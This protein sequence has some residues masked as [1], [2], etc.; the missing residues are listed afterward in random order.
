MMPDHGE[1]KDATPATA[2][3]NHSVLAELPF[4][5]RQD[6]ADAARGFIASLPEMT[7]KRSDG[8][9]VYS[10]TDYAFLSRSDA[11]DTVNPSLWR[12]AR[13]NMHHGLFQVS[14]RI[15]Q[16]RGFD[17]SNMTIIEGER[18][19]IVIDPLISTETASAALE[20]YC[21]HRGRKPVTAVIYSHSHVVHFGGVR[22]VIDGADVA[23]GNVI[24]IAPD[25]FMEEVTK[26]NVLAGTPMVRR[27]MFQFGATLPKGERAQV[28]AGLGK[29]TS[30]GTVTLIPPTQTIKEPI[31]V[32]RIDGIEMLFQLA[33]D[34]EAPCEM[35]M[36]YP[37]LRALNLAENATHN[38]HNIYPIRGAQVRDAN[39]WAKYLNEARDRFARNADVVFAQH[40][41]PIWGNAR[42]LDYLA[43]Q[44]DAYKYLHDQTLRLMN[45]GLTA[46]EIAERLTYPNSLAREWH[47]RGYYGT[48]SHNAK[49]VYQRYLGWYDANPANLN[50]LPPRARSRKSLAYMGGAAAAISRARADFAAGEYRW[51]ADVMSQV[52]FAE[53]DN[54][55][56]RELCADAL[57]QLGYQAESATWRNA[58]LLGAQELRGNETAD[59][60][61]ARASDIV[62]SLTLELFFDLLAVRLNGDKAA[63]R[64]M[65]INWRFPDTGERYV[66][67]LENCALTY[68]AERHHE[69]AEATVELDRSTLNGLMLRE[70]PLPEAM[71]KGLVRIA[72]DAAKLAELFAI[73]DDFTMAFEVIEPLRRKS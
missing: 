40:H 48:I 10:L 26:E 70:L 4:D 67:T 41:W 46:A 47:V 42:L 37:A 66:L 31:E 9:V 33:P 36:F 32:H 55:E 69:D 20:L 50:P 16:V 2:R 14:E 58:Y 49:A 39:A 35:H 3:H 5:D 43:K 56:A 54:C 28:D 51:V 1:R 57:E 71:E 12:Q 44:R 59:K 25:R 21:R 73:L 11:P 27:A 64:S 60:G 65:V 24:I 62:R 68:L 22:G 72:G 19:I 18:G 38:L 45:H 52:V 17:I 29:V 34:T 7:L 53:P 63:G 15:Y 61:T 8:R 6:F 23:A 13:L 30:R